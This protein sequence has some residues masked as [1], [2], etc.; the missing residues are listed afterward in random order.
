MPESLAPRILPPILAFVGAVVMLSYL[1]NVPTRIWFAAVLG[2]VSAAY[3]GTPVTIAWLMHR[4]VE[5]LPTDGS[6][7]G[8]VGLLLGLGSIHLIG[9]LAV[10]GKRFAEDPLGF[11]TTFFTFWRQK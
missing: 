10:L 9:G 7:H 4:G 8:V 3:V 1:H 11:V 6:V 5:W 2:S